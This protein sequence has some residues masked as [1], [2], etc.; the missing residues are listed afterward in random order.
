[1]G[2]SGSFGGYPLP[3]KTGVNVA[4]VV[5]TVGLQLRPRLALQ[6]SGAFDASHS[7][8]GYDHGPALPNGEYLKRTS[9][10]RTL[11]VPV[12]GR[13]ALT[14]RVAQRFQADI[15]GG[16]S[17]VRFNVRSDVFRMSEN[18]T[19]LATGEETS[20][21]HSACLTL[22]AGVRYALCQRFE[23][24]AEAVLN[25]QITS[26]TLSSYGANPNV[27]AGVRYRFGKAL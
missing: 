5:P 23:L 10:N 3:T 1:V 25:R 11:V 8:A 17:Y 20:T 7:Y 27:A 18:G 12:L 15:L 26:K 2:V 13:Y 22:G 16:V 21:T 6:V 24:T 9:W 19:V 14:R 4:T